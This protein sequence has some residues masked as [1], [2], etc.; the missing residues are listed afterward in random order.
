MA[1]SEK[2]V[3]GAR[4]VCG[5]GHQEIGGRRSKPH[6]PPWSLWL[7]VLL[8]A[9][10]RTRLLKTTGFM[11]NRSARSRPLCGRY[12]QSDGRQRW[13]FSPGKDGAAG[14][15]RRAVDNLHL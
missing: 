13:T 5:A 9:H 15:Q 7:L 6:M 10:A 11:R 1:H 14:L 12:V 4:T 2:L 3:R 8:E